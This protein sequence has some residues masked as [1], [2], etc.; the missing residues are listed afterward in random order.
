MKFYNRLYTSFLSGDKW[1][2][3]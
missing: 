2:S 1:W 3:S